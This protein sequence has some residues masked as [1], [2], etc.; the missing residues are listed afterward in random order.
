MPFTNTRTE[1][2][3]DGAVHLFWVCIGRTFGHSNRFFGETM[4]MT[5]LQVK[6]LHHAI[7][8]GFSG[9][10][11]EQMMRLE[12]DERLDNIVPRDRPLN[13]IV[14]ELIQWADQRGRI[15]DLI[16]AIQLARP[17]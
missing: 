1:P 17:N 7:L 13:E 15:N 8:S 5:G 14:F 9:S 12:M 2:Y 16:L 4:A 10:D 3:P 6:K 11:L